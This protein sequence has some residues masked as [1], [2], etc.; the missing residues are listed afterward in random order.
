MATK[1]YDNVVR[2]I[3]EEMDYDTIYYFNQILKK[4]F[5]HS[6]VTR[7]THENIEIALFRAMEINLITFLWDHNKQQVY[8][9]IKGFND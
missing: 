3:I 1:N 8:V 5:G 6:N 2:K 7:K 9:K 4:A